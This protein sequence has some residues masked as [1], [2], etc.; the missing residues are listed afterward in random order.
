ME[1][2]GPHHTAFPEAYSGVPS[3]PGV[4]S[5]IRARKYALRL[6]VL[7]IAGEDQSEDMSE[8]T[9]AVLCVR[10]HTIYAQWPELDLYDRRRDARTYPSGLPIIAH[11]PCRAWGRLRGLAH[12]DTDEMA[13]CV[14][15]VEQV[16]RWGG[17]LEHP[18]HSL[19][20]PEANLPLPGTHNT[21][22]W[23][24]AIQQYWFGHKASKPTWLYIVGCAPVDTPLYPLRLGDPSHTIGSS[25]RHMHRL[26]ECTKA[27]RDHTPEL[28][29]R[30][31]IDVARR[32]RTQGQQCK[33]GDHL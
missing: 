29:A 9:I 25:R 33:Q 21:D 17:V 32:C 15:I 11:P 19:L 30:W 12:R 22:G 26:P 28:L 20:W 6:G 7:R 31:L 5:G 24:L 1:Q 4:A 13:M 3:A 10:P 14:W 16:R 2:R 23:T 8:K 27:E 18:A